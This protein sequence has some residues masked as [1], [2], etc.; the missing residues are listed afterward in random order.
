MEAVW[1][2]ISK[3]H[4]ADAIVSSQDK[5]EETKAW[6]EQIHAELER[7]P[8]HELFARF[9]RDLTVRTSAYQVNHQGSASFT[10]AAHC[11]HWPI[12]CSRRKA[13]HATLSMWQIAAAG[14]NC[15][16]HA[17][18]MPCRRRSASCDYR[19]GLDIIPGNACSASNLWCCRSI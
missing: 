5:V 6:I 15:Q 7:K 2:I 9:N 19:G 11:M 16:C 3:L 1:P 13:L 10:D 17:P 12:R 4:M 8:A 18:P 14:H